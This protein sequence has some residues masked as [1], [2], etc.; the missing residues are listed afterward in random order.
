MK[1]TLKSGVVIEVVN[2]A[3]NIYGNATRWYIHDYGLFGLTIPSIWVDW[4]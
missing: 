3:I 2:R 4:T 1:G